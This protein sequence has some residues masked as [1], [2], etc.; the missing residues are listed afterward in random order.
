MFPF[1]SMKNNKI[2]SIYVSNFHNN[3]KPVKTL[4][5]K[6]SLL[7]KPSKKLNFLVNRFVNNASPEDNTDSEDVVQSKYYE[8]DEL[9][10]MKIP[11][12]DKLLALF[13]I[14]ACSLSKTLNDL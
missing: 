13:H 14:N 2:F 6:S 3:N 12:E 10:T 5:N 11:N 4:N 1:N 7:F 9:Q 8:S